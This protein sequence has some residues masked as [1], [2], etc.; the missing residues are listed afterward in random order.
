MG[1]SDELT[2]YLQVGPVLY[3]GRVCFEGQFERT[4]ALIDFL[5]IST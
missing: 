2:V 1:V 4:R 3:L 5:G